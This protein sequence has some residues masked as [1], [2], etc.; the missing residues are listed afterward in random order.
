LAVLSWLLLGLVSAHAAEEAP[1]PPVPQSIEALDAALAKIFS[2]AKIPGVSVTVVEGG[3]IVLTKG[4][5]VS[6]NVAKTPVTPETVFRAGSISKSFT[7]LAVMLLVEE[8]KLDLNAKLSDLMPELKFE[9]AWEAS[10]P[11]RLIHLIEH[12]TGFDDIGFRH[13]LIAGKDIELAQAVGLYGPY[14]SRWRPGERVSYC[15]SAPVIAGRIVEKV[16][17]KR[18]QDFIAERITGPLGMPSAYWTKEPQIEGRLS[19]S[20]KDDGVTEEP[21]MEI[22]ARPSGSLNVTSRDLVRFPMML[23]SR[24]S[25]DGVTVAKPET[26]ARFETA[27]SGA[28]ARAGLTQAYGKGV[29]AYPGKRVVFFGHDGGIDGFVAKYE[30][31]P[32]LGA[33]FVM[34]AN[35]PKFELFEA[36]DLVRGYLERNAPELKDDAKPVAAS[37]LVRFTGQYQ[38]IAPRQEILAAITSL[39]QWEDARADGDALSFNGTKRV[40][41]GGNIFRKSDAAAP[42]MVFVD[43]PD[44]VRMYT[45]TGAYRLVPAWELW[46]KVVAIGAVV[47]AFALALL[48]AILW[49]P[50]AFL[51]RLAERGGVSI[52]LLPFLAIASVIGV[53]IAV[54]TLLGIGDIAMLGTPSLPAQGLYAA[55]LIAPVLAGLAL[56]RAL[57][58]PQDAGVWVRWLAWFCAFAA[59]IACAHMGAYG[60]IGLRIWM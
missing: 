8:G 29:L 47:L 11:I 25:L 15:N 43:T 33:A 48:H 27:E 54:V 40:H 10:D 50:S 53:A 22:P 49:I 31:A 60:W 5:G 4:Y 32:S 20:Y 13:Y 30:Y 36:A 6:D 56:L 52:R 2:A 12:T 44:G 37:D 55:T 35:A 57:V 16:T 9:N 38:T 59:A 39:A 51:G 19:K 24:G 26:V 23:A 1:E 28:G 42:N 7:G 17:G 41:L 46:T 58:P 34:M 18:Y 21:F 45:P 3:Q 14:K